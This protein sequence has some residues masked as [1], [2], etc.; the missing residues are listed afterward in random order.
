V[1][2]DAIL[3]ADC[4]SALYNKGYRMHA[5]IPFLLRHGYWVLVAN[6]FAEGIG[7]PIPA[8]P[9]LLGMGALAGLGNFSIWTSLALAVAASL[10]SDVIWF[11]LGRVCVS[12]TKSL[13]GRLG[14]RALLIAKFIPGLGATA[15]PLAGLTRMNPWKFIAADATGAVVWS[16]TYLAIGYM[17]RNQLE[18]AA[19]QAGRMGSLLVL[20]IGAALT[21]YIG[22]KYYQRRRFIRGLRVARITPEDLMRMITAGDPIA[23]VDLRHELEVENDR[24]KLPG[25]IWMTLDE[26]EIRHEEIPRDRQVILY[27][28]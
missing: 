2:Q 5:I 10:T 6:V 13:F 1:G 14:A 7:L 27:C 22:W 28:S 17:F 8:L 12:N 3:R 21:G 19:E 20:V 16:A 11:R 18:L 23:V 4:Q 25:A 9:V 24:V 26:I 15:A